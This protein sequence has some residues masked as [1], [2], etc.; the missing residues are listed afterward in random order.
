[1]ES[2]FN[3][4]LHVAHLSMYSNKINM[5]ILAIALER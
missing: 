3:I 1:M 2:Q 5:A 4:G